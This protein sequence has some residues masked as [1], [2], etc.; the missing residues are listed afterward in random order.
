MEG[1]STRDL[2][3]AYGEQERVVFDFCRSQKEFINYHIIEAFK[4]GR[5]F[6]SKYESNLRVFKPC[7]VVCFANFVPEWF[8][9]SLDRW[10][11]LDLSDDKFQLVYPD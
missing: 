11:C 8:K 6:S 7:K 1:G 9:L 5:L 4:N 3:Y 10:M 2:A